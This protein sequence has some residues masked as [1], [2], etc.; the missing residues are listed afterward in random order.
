MPVCPYVPSFFLNKVRIAVAVYV[1]AF[2][3]E[4]PFSFHSKDL[5]CRLDHASHAQPCQPP[6]ERWGAGMV[7]CLER[8]A[9]LHMAQLIPLPLTV[10]CFSKI[11]FG[12]TFLVPV[13]LGSPGQRAVKR[14][15]VC[16]CVC[17]CARA[18]TRARVPTTR[19]YAMCFEI[20]MVTVQIGQF[21][22]HF[23][24]VVI[25][26][27]TCYNILGPTCSKQLDKVI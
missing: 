15:R 27:V 3:P 21:L 4:S 6:P 26:F 17:V 25:C 10:S 1:S 9:D 11:Q 14:A 24:A 13:H 20:L 5:G 16:V 19:Q 2:L 22:N 7:V 23:L 18:R 12:F 8:G